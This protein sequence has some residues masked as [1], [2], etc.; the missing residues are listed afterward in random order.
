M[1]HP[2]LVSNPLTV[3]SHEETDSM[4]PCNM[5]GYAMFLLWEDNYW[6]RDASYYVPKYITEFYIFSMEQKISPP[7]GLFPI[8]HWYFREKM[9]QFKTIVFMD[10]ET[11]GTAR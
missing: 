6:E 3:M 4:A 9:P 11:T 8:I 10:T 2:V 5:F 1:G 7:Y